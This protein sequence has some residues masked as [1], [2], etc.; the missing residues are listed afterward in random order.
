MISHEK[1]AVLLTM[2]PVVLVHQ[3]YE[4][5]EQNERL[6]KQNEELSKRNET[7]R[8]KPARYL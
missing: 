4:A 8:G 6:T 7:P 3:L 2:A 1:E 5:L